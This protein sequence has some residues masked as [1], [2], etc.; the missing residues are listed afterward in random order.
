MEAAQ[1]E[2]LAPYQRCPEVLPHAPA[3]PDPGEQ[4]LNDP[5]SGM[6]GEAN[7]ILGLL[8]HLNLRVLPAWQPCLERLH[9]PCREAWIMAD[10]F[11]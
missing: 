10:K 1:K 8:G 4:A 6:D 9:I 5:K 11:W 7:M 3:A 2:G